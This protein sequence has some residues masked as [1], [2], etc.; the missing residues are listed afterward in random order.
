VDGHYEAIR[1]LEDCVEDL[2]DHLF[3]PSSDYS[4]IRRRGFEIRRAIAGL[5]R[6]AV[7]MHDVVGRLMRSDLHLV[8]DALQP[9]YQDV[10]DHVQRTEE[11]VD[12]A[13]DHVTSVLD[14]NL[15]EQ[16]NELNEITKKLA[17]WAAIIA[18][19]TAVTGFYGQNVTFPG[20]GTHGG[21]IVAVIV[22]V[23]LASGVY[24]LL[25]S[26]RWL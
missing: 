18:V 25:R 15:T 20:F 26:R 14:A 21:F 5:R 12:S 7:P 6:V 11:S 17:S 24:A 8:T 3:E 2:E 1:G 16:S 10:Y 4:D 9:Y 22:M 19:P 23:V 13:R